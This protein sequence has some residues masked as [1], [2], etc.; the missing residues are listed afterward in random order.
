M[1]TTTSSWAFPTNTATILRNCYGRGWSWRRRPASRRST[2]GGRAASPTI[3]RRCAGGGT[4]RTGGTARAAS[5]PLTNT[6][7]WRSSSKWPT[8]WAWNSTI[9]SPS[10]TH[11][12]GSTTIQGPPNARS[13]ASIRRATRTSPPTD[14]SPTASTT[15]PWR[16]S[17]P[18]SRSC[19]SISTTSPAA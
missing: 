7:F 14:S 12:A 5:R 15:A 8:S 11:P 3:P 13:T 2:S 9:G 18:P 1:S 17:R 10:S 6:T 19:F 16:T 4:G